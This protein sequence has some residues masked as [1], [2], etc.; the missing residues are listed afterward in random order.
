MVED[1]YD[2]ILCPDQP[3][4]NY[5]V[6]VDAIGQ[7]IYKDFHPDLIQHLREFGFK[8]ELDIA[9]CVIRNKFLDEELNPDVTRGT[10]TL[11]VRHN[12]QYLHIPIQ[13]YLDGTYWL[14]VAHRAQSAPLLRTWYY[15]TD[16]KILSDP[17]PE[18]RADL[19]RNI[20]RLIK[21]SDALANNFK[22]QS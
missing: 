4:E 14:L 7:H 2:E 21:Y 9:Y 6:T 20:A 3:E 8:G 10:A 15:V 13:A 5:S 16:K 11:I 12:H 22:E 1:L 18:D 19:I 17:T